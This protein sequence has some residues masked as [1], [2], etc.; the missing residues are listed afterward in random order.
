[1]MPALGCGLRPTRVRS[2][3][4]S[5]LSG[6]PRCRPGATGE[7][8]GRRSAKVGTRAAAT[9]TRSHFE[10]RRR[11]H[12]RSRAADEAWDGPILRAGGRRGSRHANSASVRSVRYGRRRMTTGHPTGQTGPLPGFQTVFSRGVW[13]GSSGICGT[14][15]SFSRR[16]RSSTFSSMS[17]MKTRVPTS[18]S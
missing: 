18:R 4:R 15:T 14:A 2:C 10:R 8:S 1:M 3:S 7:S 6:V 17:I 16:R 9:A 13:S 11:W 12:S 5:T